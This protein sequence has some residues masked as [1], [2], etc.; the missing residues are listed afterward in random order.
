LGLIVGV[1]AGALTAEVDSE[2]TLRAGVAR[3]SR[4]KFRFVA[5]MFVAAIYWL[6][7]AGFFVWSLRFV[8]RG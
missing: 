7:I 1:F 5:W 4:K 2:L 8:V 3:E 6:A